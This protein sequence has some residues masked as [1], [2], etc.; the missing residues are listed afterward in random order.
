MQVYIWGTGNMADEYLG[1]GELHEE[2]II[3]FIESRKSKDFFRGKKV[4][5]PEELVK[6]GGDYDY[7][8]VCVNHFGREIY[9]ICKK[10]G[11]DTDKLILMDNW[12][13]ADGS[14]MNTPFTEPRRKIMEH[15]IGVETIFP[16][17]DAYIKGNDARGRYIVAKRNCSDFG[18]SHTLVSNDPFL[19][20]EYQ[21]DYFRYRTFEFVADEIL[22]QKVEGSLAELGVFKGTFSRLINAKFPKRKLYL[23]DT[24]ESFNKK[25]FQKEVEAGRCPDSFFDVFLKTSVEDV[26]SI[27][28][29]P[30]QCIVRKGLFPATTEGLE[31]ETYAFVS[32]DVD[33]EWSILEGI[34]YFY[35]RLNRGGAIFIHDYNHQSLKGVR[36]AVA[37]YQDEIGEAICKVPLADWGG[38]LVVVK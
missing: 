9:D 3:G 24:F 17:F 5:E 8:L 23:F 21:T 26:I 31:E 37:A 13:W 1:R 14:R 4:C 30:L 36:K 6:K 7:I 32:I 12:E 27:M 34:R 29:Y 20:I 18:E 10:L 25:E 15:S 2:E 16:I 22:R 38:T 35:P 28:E 11:I 19:G 33:F